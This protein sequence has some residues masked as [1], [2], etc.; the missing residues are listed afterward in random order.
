MPAQVQDML[1][2]TLA[3][4]QGRSWEY[5]LMGAT[6]AQLLDAIQNAECVVSAEEYYRKN[7]TGDQVRAVTALWCV[8]CVVRGVGCHNFG[9]TWAV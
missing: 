1:T 6:P 8:L 3:E 4:V 5:G 7:Y 9:V 2:T